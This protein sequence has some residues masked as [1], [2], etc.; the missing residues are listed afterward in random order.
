MLRIGAEVAEA[1]GFARL[2]GLRVAVLCNP[3]S[4][5]RSPRP[6]HAS[7]H[8][9]DAMRAHGLDVVRLFGP[10]HGL[11]S[12]AQDLI[13][14]DG[15]FDPVFDLPVDTLYGR[16]VDSLTPRPDALAGI[17][18]LVFDVQDVGA[19]YYTYAATL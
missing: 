16:T 13:A 11:W 6:P 14:V 15:G 10:E 9:V 4:L 7:V 2:R 1:Q 19:R 12:T 18:V 3:S 5:V 17:D 8:L